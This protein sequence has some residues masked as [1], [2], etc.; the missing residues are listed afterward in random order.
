MSEDTITSLI[1]ALK[2]SIDIEKDG[3]IIR[4]GS[5]ANLST[6]RGLAAEK[7][8]IAGNPEDLVLLDVS[9]QV[10]AGIDQVRA[11]QVI[12]IDHKDH[13]KEVPRPRRLPFVGNLPEMLPNIT[14]GWCRMFAD[15][16]PLVSISILSNEVIGT[17]DPA[18]A[19]LFAK[20]SEY[21]T[22]KLSAGLLQV[23]NFAGQ[24][25]FTTDTDDMDWKLAH[26]LL[27]PAFSPRAI[28]AYLHDMGAI[29]MQTIKVLEQYQ[30]TEGVEVLVWTTRLTF[31]TIG[32]CGFGYEFGLLDS[33]DA[34]SHPFIEAM[35][36]C[37][38]QSANRSQQTALMRNLPIPQQKRYWSDIQ[39]MSDTVDKVIRDR[40]SSEEATNKDKDLLGFMLNA[41]DEQGLGL[42][43]ENIRNQVLT[44]LIAGH[45]TTAN[46]LAWTLYEISRHPEVEARL[47]QEIANLGITHTEIPT[48]E[49][50]SN[51]KYTH[52]VLKETLRKHPPL[53]ELGKYCKKDCI[54]PGGYKI[55][56]GSYVDIQ[57]YAMHHNE[58]V[59]PN[60]KEY[61]PDR[62]SPEEEQKRSR[63]AWL[64]F[65]TG[66][67]AC[68]G[69]AFA[70]QEAKIVLAMLLHRFKF[71]YD[72]PDINFDPQMP[73]TKPVDLLMNILPRTDMPEPSSEPLSVPPKDPTP[74][75]APRPEA[76]INHMQ[77][78]KGQPTEKL[79]SITF[80]F[81]TQTGTAQDYASQLA[82]QARAF[83]F[84][85]VE[86]IEMDRWNVLEGT[87]EPSPSGDLVVICTATYNGQPPDSAEKFSKFIAGKVGN[88]ANS[89]L[90]N[91]LKYA[92]F[93]LGNVQWRTYQRFPCIVDDALEELGAERFFSAGKGNADA[94][95]DAEFNE[96]CAHF[97]VRTLTNYGLAVPKSSSVVPSANVSS[98]DQQSVQVQFIGPSNEAKWEAATQNRNGET[99]CSIEIRRELQQPGSGRHTCHMEIDISKLQPLSGEH[100]YEPGDH[101]EVMPANDPATVEAVALSFGWVLDSVFEVD[102]ESLSASVSPRSLAK[103]IQGPCTVRNA[104]TY[105]ADLSSPP[106]RTLLAIFAEHLRQVDASTA[107]AFS[108]MIMPDSKD[109][110]AFIARHHNLL[111]LQRAFPQVNQLEFALFL[112]AVPVMQPRRYSIASSPLQHPRSVHLTVGIV[113]DKEDGRVYHGLASNFLNARAQSFRGGLKSSR[114][115]F[116]LPRD[117]EVPLIMVGAG[118]GISPFRGFLQHRAKQPSAAASALVFGCRHPKQ[119]AIYKDELEQ[120]VS[121]GVLSDLWIAYSR[122]QPPSPVK[123]VQHQLLANAARVWTLISKEQAHVYVCGA[124]AMSRDV[125]RAFITIAK[126]FGHSDPEHFVDNLLDEGRYKEDVWG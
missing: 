7:L 116:S 113:E 9:D 68:I 38:K 41:R 77:Q 89:K 125:R 79:P 64:P 66:P 112:A 1:V 23:K 26:K 87:Y 107:E 92:V 76:L 104:L 96:W 73:T 15:Y 31:E 10:L 59:Y 8:G 84:K 51:L 47:L 42:S 90:L 25:L 54:V 97:W 44:F 14:M 29:S 48:F 69:M 103:M 91:G 18:I 11:Q 32:R 61:D 86:T 45:D 46:M 2:G 75:K 124:G 82:S 121:D 40:K 126:S 81:G 108:N 115:T 98:G 85:D 67:R 35:A 111:D 70:L 71:T 119:D 36:Y 99:N 16:G 27:M 100:M 118:T 53:R 34:P 65:S 56:A 88:E 110:A 21:F 37:L 105:F 117:P 60:P 120:Y 19:E 13:I 33:R 24:G 6:V 4:F 55:H 52:Q 50:V 12:H 62:F 101:L 122:L 78:Q 114:S 123:Y 39:L 28:K 74:A 63:F 93:G 30:P 17:N 102:R 94:D 109:Y 80:L 43:D 57:V 72:G 3:R 58:K 49:Q 106:S 95:M 22:K 20:E 83:G 5:G